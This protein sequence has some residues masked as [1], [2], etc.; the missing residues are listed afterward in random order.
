MLQLD[1]KRSKDLI[2]NLANADRVTI[3]GSSCVAYLEAV[4][5]D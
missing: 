5:A 4:Q 1:L 3:F 2:Q